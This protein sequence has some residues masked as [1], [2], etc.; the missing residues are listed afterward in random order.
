MWFFQAFT[1][2]SQDTEAMGENTDK[3]KTLA[4]KG[5]GV[6]TVFGDGEDQKSKAA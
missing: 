5:W 6:N 1:N 3:L 4:N 2:N